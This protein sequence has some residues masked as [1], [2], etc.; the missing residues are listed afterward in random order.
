[1]RACACTV[2]ECTRL[3]APPSGG[4][5]R[6]R[7]DKMRTMI[8]VSQPQ[9]AFVADGIELLK[10]QEAAWLETV[11]NL[12]DDIDASLPGHLVRLVRADGEWWLDFVQVEGEAD[13]DNN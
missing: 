7:E 3:H 8:N 4:G 12:V 5:A 6:K 9:F 13:A 2:V 11:A 1:M 10:L